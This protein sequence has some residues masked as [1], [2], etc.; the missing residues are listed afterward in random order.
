[1]ALTNAYLITTKNLQDFLN[2]IVTAQA[3][4]KFSYGFL[5]SLVSQVPMIASSSAC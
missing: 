4:E 2:A 3:P 5:E 1:M